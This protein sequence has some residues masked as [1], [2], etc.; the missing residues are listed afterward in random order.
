M[1]TRL[2]R[3]LRKVRLAGGLL[4]VLLAVIV[5]DYQRWRRKK[6]EQD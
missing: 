4:L 1:K 3:W 6:R 5:L 2:R